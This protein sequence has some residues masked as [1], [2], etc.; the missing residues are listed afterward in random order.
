[1]TPQDIAGLEALVDAY[2]MACIQSCN[3]P[4]GPIPKA[5]AALDDALRTLAAENERLRWERVGL[6]SAREDIGASNG[7]LVVE[8]DSLRASLARIADPKAFDTSTELK[9]LARVALKQT[10]EGA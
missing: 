2:G 1:M 9:A 7:R 10:V 5:R 6:I 3:E 4:P 8:R